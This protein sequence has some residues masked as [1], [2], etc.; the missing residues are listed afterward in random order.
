MNH[1]GPEGIAIS[2]SGPKVRSD[3]FATFNHALDDCFRE[4]LPNTPLSDGQKGQPGFSYSESRG[5][6]V[7]ETSIDD[8]CDALMPDTGWLLVDASGRIGTYQP[9]DMIA[10]RRQIVA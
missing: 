1:R 10:D 6:G 2:F 3:F 7:A 9:E 5:F 8:G 4:G